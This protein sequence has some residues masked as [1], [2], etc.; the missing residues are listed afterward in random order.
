MDLEKI[1]NQ[2]DQ[3]DENIIDLLNS[4]MELVKSVADT[5][6]KTNAPIFRPQ[7]EKEIVERLS[8][9]ASPLIDK[10]ALESIFW[11]IFALSRNLQKKEQVAFL[12]P[13]GSYTHEAART[14]FGEKSDYLS[15]ASIKAVFD[16][17]HNK[18]AKYGI[19]PIE[20]NTE[21]IVGETL[22][23]L[24]EK[25]VSIVAEIKMDIHHS[26]ASKA[27]DLQQIK[28]IYSKDVAFGQCRN[29]LSAHALENVELIPVE[30]TAKAAKLAYADEFAGAICSK[31]ASSIYKLP[32]M[33]SQIEDNPKNQ[34]R[35]ILISDYQNPP[36]GLDKTSILIKTQHKP[37]Q[38][39]TLLMDFF[40]AKI[41]LFKIESRPIRNEKDFLAWFYI[42]FDGHF[43]DKNVQSVILK[44]SSQ[45]KWLGSYLKV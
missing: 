19:I 40:E 7:R 16:C 26:F 24:G 28:K 30:S 10:T 1:R 22:D 9:K 12:G 14:R 18:T 42:D 33:F 15:F 2:I 20:N 21:G 44:H 45:V 36:T 25:D 37:G 27:K 39:A 17:V 6:N 29:F 4:R 3:I 11:E 41:N 43:N 5:K 34:T 31:I 35:F 8:K 23:F 13:L 38:L 32:I